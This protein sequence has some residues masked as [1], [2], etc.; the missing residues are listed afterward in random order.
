M[1]VI[2]WGKTP[3]ATDGVQQNM[4]DEGVR[5]FEPLQQLGE[6]IGRAP[7]EYRPDDS[8]PPSAAT[9]G[10]DESKKQTEAAVKGAARDEIVQG[11]FEI[12]FSEDMRIAA[13]E[14]NANLLGYSA[15]LKY[16][17][18]PSL[19]AGAGTA[20]YDLRA[21][22]ESARYYV[23]ITAYDFQAATRQQQK[24]GLWRTVTSIDARGN[25]FDES[26][27]A[28]MDRASR[29]FGRDSGRLVRE[30]EYTPHVSFGELKVLGVVDQEPGV[31]K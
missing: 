13:L 10:N 30:F 6:G 24:K 20:Y 25:R 31:R 19:Y 23:A 14:Q 11:M 2:H 16:R 7:G 3:S 18:N 21:D 9:F 17:D 29:Y 28:M 26:L 8:V 4:L 27:M 15:D 1:L 5:S 12:R 22:L